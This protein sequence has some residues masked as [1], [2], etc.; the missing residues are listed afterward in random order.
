METEAFDSGAAPAQTG[1]RDYIASLIR[2]MPGRLALALSLMVALSLMEGVGLLL[3]VPLLGLVG[4]DIDQ[5]ALRGVAEWLRGGFEALGLEPTLVTVLIA[6]VIIT[7]LHALLRRWQTTVGLSLNHS[8][9]VLLRRRLYRAIA[10]ANWLFFVRSRTS[11]FTHVLT[12]EV[13]RVGVATYQ[14][15]QLS[16]TIL[17]GAVYVVFALKISTAMTALVFLCGAGLIFLLKGKTRLARTAGEATSKAMK[18]LYSAISEH[19]GGMKTAKSYG[20]EERHVEIFGRLTE[21]VHRAYIQGVRSQADAKYW[22]DVGSVLILSLIVYVCFKVLSLSTAEVLLLLFLFARLM[23]RFSSIHQGYQGFVNL[24][25]AF[26][27]VTEMEARCRAAAETAGGEG[28]TVE[29]KEGVRLAKATFAYEKV[30]VVRD[31]DLALPAGAT[32]A[33]VGPSGAGK[34]TVADLIMGLITPEKGRVLVDRRPL[35]SERIR[36]WRERIGYVPQ[37]TFL[38]HDTI[39]ANLL[40]ANPG[41]SEADIRRSLEMAAA[42]SFVFGMREGLDTLVGERGVRLSGGERQRLALARALLRQP[43]LLILDEATSDLDAENEQ[44]IHRAIQDLHGSMTI[45]VISHRLSAVQGADTIYVLEAGT[46]VESGTW[47]SLMTEENG[48]FR[49]LCAAQGIGF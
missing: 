24:L 15:L 45:L 32:S 20:A 5:G 10:Y 12:E 16:A 25:P 7:S 6:Y 19:V 46:L 11:D 38:F 34:S 43:A 4:L 36:P 39:R 26:S 33:I 37:E 3:L 35:S 13:Q 40:W 44:R 1:F 2:E 30:P 18:R 27:S 17:A 41:A 48:R 42:H 49:S 21:G 31:L 14:L 47:E 8:F 29:L 28:G 22:F 9:V 23:P